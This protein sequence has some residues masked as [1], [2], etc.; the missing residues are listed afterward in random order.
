MI[1]NDEQDEQGARAVLARAYPAPTALETE[2]ALES[3]RPLLVTRPEIRWM[4]ALLR[5]AA[6]LVLGVLTF[7]AGMTAQRLRVGRD[8]F[9]PF[10][11]EMRLRPATLSAPDGLEP[12]PLPLGEDP[13]TFVPIRSYRVRVWQQGI[14]GRRHLMRDTAL[15][16]NDIHFDFGE[17]AVG[18]TES[19]GPH[20]VLS[21]RVS[22]MPIGSRVSVVADVMSRTPV[23]FTQS[24]GTNRVRMEESRYRREITIP[25]LATAWF[26]PMG[27]PQPDRRGVAIEIQALERPA[28]SI[29]L[30][31]LSVSARRPLPLGALSIRAVPTVQGAYLKLEVGTGESWQ[32]V[33]D[34]PRFVLT[35]REAG[36]LVLGMPYPES[37]VRFTLEPPTEAGGP[38]CFAWRW[39]RSTNPSASMCL[40]LRA[41]SSRIF[42]LHGT[43]GKR[44]RITVLETFTRAPWIR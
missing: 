29:V 40:P 14:D 20:A 28:S 42:P 32:T 19:M 30:D 36:F 2:L 41:D 7:G 16:G 38:M 12:V 11:D 39:A 27:M 22:I 35:R 10:A 26:Y 1:A 13:S 44:L 18:Y 23:G 15:D 8:S 25:R 21:A 34:R 4:P 31:S 3:V 6:V 9:T 43:Q 37:Q 24:E 17:Q 5:I 33:F